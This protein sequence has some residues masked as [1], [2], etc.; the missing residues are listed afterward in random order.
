MEEFSKWDNEGTVELFSIS[1]KIVM[2]AICRMLFGTAAINDETLWMRYYAAFSMLDPERALTEPLT[3]FIPKQKQK[4][5]NTVVSVVKQ[6]LAELSEDDNLTGLGILSDLIEEEG[7]VVDPE[8]IAQT[9][10]IFSLGAF[11]NLYAAVG[12]SLYHATN[13]KEWGKKVREER[14]LLTTFS[15]EEL[16]QCNFTKSLTQEMTRFYARGFFLRFVTEPNG[17]LLPSGFTVP[18]GEMCA[19]YIPD[20]SF[21]P[22]VW[23]NPYE[24]KAERFLDADEIRDKGVYW[25][26]FGRGKHPCLGMQFS[27]AQ[28]VLLLQLL[29]E[30]F[31]FKTTMEE[32]PFNQNQ[33]GTIFKPLNPVMA[34]YKRIQ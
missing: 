7:G 11:T 9:F 30:R 34:E 2:K 25:T 1:R 12:W 20:L 26:G 31:E 18:H 6:A 15:M 3:I 8:Y 22:T 10:I 27:L 29:M 21:E 4:A 23:E 16:L 24:V 13:N 19:I 32:V 14:Q 5:F 28:A 33:L 17:L